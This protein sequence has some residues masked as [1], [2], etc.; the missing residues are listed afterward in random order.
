[1]AY[2]GTL[3]DF[4]AALSK[5]ESDLERLRQDLCN[6]PKFRPAD[7]FASIEREDGKPEIGG[8]EIKKFLDSKQL[9]EI[10]EAEL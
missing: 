2:L 5:G 9:Y 7:V 3:K 4:L 8:M 6:L 10:D 1:M